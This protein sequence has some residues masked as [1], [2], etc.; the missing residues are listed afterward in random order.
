MAL[1]MELDTASKMFA[2]DNLFCITAYINSFSKVSADLE[3]KL[4]ITIDTFPELKNR[5]VK[6]DTTVFMEPVTINLK[7]HYTVKKESAEN[8]DTYTKLVEKTPF[9][10]DT[11]W[12]FYLL[13]DDENQKYRLYFKINHAYGDGV[14]VVEMV[15]LF[16]SIKQNKEVHLRSIPFL[17]TLYY[18]IIGTFLI[19]YDSLKTFLTIFTKSSPIYTTETD[20]IR[21]SFDLD[22]IKGFANKSNATINDVL[23]LVMLRADKSYFG[24]REILSLSPVKVKGSLNNNL[25]LIVLQSKNTNE[26]DDIHEKFNTLKYSLYIPIVSFIINTVG[27]LLPLQIIKGISDYMLNNLDYVYT[28]VI[29]PASSGLGVQ[30]PA[31][32]GL[33]VQGPASSGL[34]Q[35][36]GP[37]IDAYFQITPRN[38][39]IIFNVI[40]CYSLI[41]ITCSFKEGV[42][43]DK[44]KYEKCIRAAYEE[45]TSSLLPSEDSSV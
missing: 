23:Y 18:I 44:V 3:K 31:S 42:I 36:L 37:E 11:Q 21:L 2:I 16:Y 43:S 15:K 22:T 10:S 8:F 12:F 6:N 33:G 1:I 14:R 30:G 20:T 7:D 35:D 26:L 41:N 40:S 39:E 29:G 27:G 4:R 45:I 13:E 38:K 5:I 17:N 19:L 9:Q 28:N 24:E 34:G 32:S 25:S